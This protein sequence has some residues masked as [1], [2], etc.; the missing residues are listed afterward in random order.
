MNTV[1]FAEIEIGKRF[2]EDCGTPATKV[3]ATHARY[4]DNDQGLYKFRPEE[5]VTPFK[6]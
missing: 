5:K 3:S 1:T 2:W 4:E 6:E